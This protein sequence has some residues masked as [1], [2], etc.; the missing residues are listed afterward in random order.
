MKRMMIPGLA[1]GLARRL[2]LGGAL[3]AGL[4][5]TAA[6]QNYSLFGTNFG[7]RLTQQDYKLATAA[8]V[9]L[10]DETPAKAGLYEHWHNPASGNGGKLTI[11]GLYTKNGLPC[12]KVKSTTL[13]NAKTGL[14]PRSTTLGACEVA[15]GEWKSDT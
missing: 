13:F 3:A 7:A 11:L 5:G 9:T 14:A 6:A 1:W 12:R 2:A 4:G 8:V 10:L 15:P